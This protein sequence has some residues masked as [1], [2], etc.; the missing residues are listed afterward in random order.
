MPTAPQGGQG[1]LGN[2]FESSGFNPFSMPTTAA[3]FT[4]AGDPGTAG[5]L[6]RINAPAAPVESYVPTRQ[7]GGLVEAG[8]PVEG[9]TS[10]LQELA[11]DETGAQILEEVVKALQDPEN[12]ESAN[13]ISSFDGAFPGALEELVAAM[14]Q[15]D[16]EDLMQSGGLISGDGDG[17]ADD[18][19]GIVN[20]GQ[21]D[22]YPILTGDGEY[23]VAA[24]VVAGLGSGNSKRGE[25][26]LDQ[27]Q[28][29]VRVARTGNPQQP[30]PI[31]L[32]AVLPKTYGQMDV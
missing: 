4:A 15:A 18:R 3:Q 5:M 10:V 23:V 19:L 6:N 16:P 31:D 21:A 7:A 2:L 13:T 27:L 32:S 8:A 9:E 11:Q 25:S 17:M 22:S 28:E 30:P 14:G 29:N 1:T 20:P 12:P 26:V 24:D